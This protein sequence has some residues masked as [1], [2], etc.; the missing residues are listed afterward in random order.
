LYGYLLRHD[1]SL[2]RYAIIYDSQAVG[3]VCIRYPWLLG[4]CIELIGIHHDYHGRGIGKQILQWIE[5]RTRLK[6]KN[7]WAVVSGFNDPA[8][9]FYLHAGFSE[10]ARIQ[11]LILRDHD[12]ILMR[13]VIS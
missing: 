9:K 13:K 7:V 8:F 12:E 10:T 11:D 1:P 3:A 4:P 2:T 5:A 6:S